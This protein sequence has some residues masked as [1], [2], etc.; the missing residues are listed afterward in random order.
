M[1]VEK[2]KLWVSVKYVRESI[3]DGTEDIPLHWS[4]SDDQ[5]RLVREISVNQYDKNDIPDDYARKVANNG[6]DLR[7]RQENKWRDE[8]TDTKTSKQ[9]KV[10]WAIDN[11]E[12]LEQAKAFAKDRSKSVAFYDSKH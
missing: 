7:Q 10:L 11:A 8:V 9:S 1:F 2:K 6:L 4:L 5:S 3:I 12:T